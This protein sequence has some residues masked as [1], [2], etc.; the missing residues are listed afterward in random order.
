MKLEWHTIGTIIITVIAVGG[1][2][3]ALLR[4]FFMTTKKCTEMQHICQ[5]GICKKI[6]E[7]KKEVKENREVVSKH[8]AEVSGALGRIEGKLG[9]N[10]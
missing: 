4:V 5:A 10:G 8:Y 7:L 6:D 3:V 1:V 2:M 9:N